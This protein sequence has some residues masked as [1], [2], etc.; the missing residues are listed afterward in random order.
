M[1]RVFS[2]KNILWGILLGLMFVGG[3]MY[4][5]DLMDRF[6]SSAPN[7]KKKVTALLHNQEA[8][9]NP[10]VEKISIRLDEEREALVSSLSKDEKE[11]DVSHDEDTYEETE[12]EKGIEPYY[13]REESKWQELMGRSIHPDHV[14]AYPYHECFNAGASEHKFPL[15]LVLGLAAY[16]SNFDPGSFMDQKLGIMH[17]GWPDPSNGM[18]VQKREELMNDPCMNIRLACRFL[19][20]LLSKSEG[21]LVPALVAYRDQLNVVRPDRITR[22]DLIFSAQL[23][24]QVEKVL[25]GPFEK[26]GMYPFLAFNNR[27]TAED[28]IASIKGSTGVDLWVGQKGYMYMVFIPAVNEEEKN[29]KV[30]LI[31]EK[32]GING[33]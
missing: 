31:S 3:W 23:R 8:R 7:V 5:P 30:T 11:L 33:K 1:F 16:L 26:K 18:G 9:F 14:D 21:K 25:Q 13:A 28:F 4:Y 6:R 15:S 24:R 29:H 2:L 20:D 32:A 27:K 12:S 10:Y 22:A 17:L 19:A